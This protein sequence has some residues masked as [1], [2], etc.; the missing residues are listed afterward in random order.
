MYQ[1]LQG[2]PRG[3]KLQG[4]NVI[5]MS[6]MLK[7]CY[8]IYYQKKKKLQIQKYIRLTQQIAESGTPMT[9]LRLW[10]MYHGEIRN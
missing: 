1:V 7:V 3:K 5:Y 10:D 8:L 2:R 6:Y 4:T 9:P